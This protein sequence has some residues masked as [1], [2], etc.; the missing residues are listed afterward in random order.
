MVW[1]FDE[2]DL[3]NSRLN[4][5]KLEKRYFLPLGPNNISFEPE[6]IDK[7]YPYGK[8]V[9]GWRIIVNTNAKVSK[10]RLKKSDLPIKKVKGEVADF[11]ELIL[12]KDLY[13]EK[14]PVEGK[15]PEVSHPVIDSLTSYILEHGRKPEYLTTLDKIRDLRKKSD[16]LSKSFSILRSY[17]LEGVA[18]PFHNDPK[19]YLNPEESDILSLEDLTDI[20]FSKAIDSKKLKEVQS[21]INT[22]LFE[23]GLDEEYMDG[24][25]NSLRDILE[26]YSNIRNF[27]EGKGFEHSGLVIYG[28]PGTGK[29]HLIQE[30][31]IKI[32]KLLGFET[33]Q[34]EIGTMLS[35]QY[36]GGL[37][38][39][40][41]DKIFKPAIKLIRESKKPC[42]IYID[43]A[44][45]LLKKG[46]H[47]WRQQ[48]IEAIKSFIN[49]SRYPGIIV[50]FATNL[51]ASEF[52][53]ALTRDGR[54]K[55]VEIPLPNNIRCKQMWNYVNEKILFPKQL[56]FRFDDTQI[57]HLAAL[58]EHKVNV[59][60]ITEI[61]KSY[62]TRK[63]LGDM[64]EIF[65]DSFL[66]DFGSQVKIRLKK[67]YDSRVS[68]LSNIGATGYTDNAVTKQELESAKNTYAKHLHELE[69]VL[70]P[71]SESTLDKV[72]SSLNALS[73]NLTSINKTYTTLILNLNNYLGKSKNLAQ[74]SDVITSIVLNLE[75]LNTSLYGDQYV[76][77]KKVLFDLNQRF[78]DLHKII[79]NPNSYVPHE[80]GYFE[81]I[82]FLVHKLPKQLDLDLNLQNISNDESENNLTSDV[83]K[84]PSQ[85]D[86]ENLKS[87]L[88]QALIQI[89][90]LEDNLR[91][92]FNV[93]KKPLS[94]PKI[95]QNV[96]FIKLNVGKLNKNNSHFNLFGTSSKD[97]IKLCES[98]TLLFGQWEINPTSFGEEKF[99]AILGIIKRL[100]ESLQKD[101]K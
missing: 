52:D 87:S 49:K 57:N 7:T 55:P 25:S 23:M 22:L 101:L 12:S 17:E 76:E 39:N 62:R 80:K 45:D 4:K 32:Y 5:I 59:A 82:P 35:N 71:N 60:A 20:D 44:T 81:L 92:S 15:Q 3:K 10:S 48:G 53:D 9:L 27:S 24:D 89:M 73:L 83:S 13:Y 88:K 68:N 58:C 34:E 33:H 19:P 84:T 47:E 38:A 16:D 72:S 74:C 31:L 99:N 42:F 29:T 14:E 28:P 94:I 11:Y 30:S 43:E 77:L 61:S 56:N 96:I 50:C 91:Q 64:D 93:G 6:V 40:V 2:K 75:I 46:G 97:K 90:S 95:L 78:E 54:L 69:L 70:D 18:Y 79:Q 26:I 66:S 63:K 98:L 86:Q 67:D 100:V 37:A 21:E 65:F 8:N 36:V 85:E 51:E 1:F 41:T